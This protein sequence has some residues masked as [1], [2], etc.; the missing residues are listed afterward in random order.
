[1]K[2][3]LLA[4]FLALP[5]VAQPIIQA[6]CTA[7]SMTVAAA[8]SLSV[9]AAGR[10]S[11]FARNIGTQPATF[12][13]VGFA[14]DFMELRQLDQADVIDVFTQKQ[15]MTRAAKI[16]RVLEFVGMVAVAAAGQQYWK[17][18]VKAVSGIAIVA[19][20]ATKFG[21]Y[22]T[23]Q[24]PPTTNALAGMIGTQDIVL[25]P[26]QGIQWK[27]YASKMQGASHVG[28]KILTQPGTPVVFQAIPVP[29]PGT[30]K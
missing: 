13:P 30:A 23:K 10:W 9:A 17:I 20:G 8:G 5:V 1:M 29:A 24:I 12:S 14:L 21:E 28:P 4:A 6:G 15:K 7:D 27:V 22:A 18:G 11:C 16:A 19:Y 26:G 3:A 2:L 25:Q